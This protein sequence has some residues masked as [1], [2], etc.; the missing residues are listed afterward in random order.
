MYFTLKIPSAAIR[1]F[2]VRAKSSRR[3]AKNADC[4]CRYSDFF[5]AILRIEMIHHRRRRIKR[6]RNWGVRKASFGI[7][8]R[9]K[10]NLPLNI[11]VRDVGSAEFFIVETVYFYQNN[12]RS[13]ADFKWQ[14]HGFSVGGFG[15]EFHLV[16]YR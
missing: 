2:Y 12:D 16:Y 14:R 10:F 13:K 8:F 1:R 4:D 3:N 6:M 5:F 11:W 15:R 9:C 7:D